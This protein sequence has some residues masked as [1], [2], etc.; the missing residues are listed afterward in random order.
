MLALRA[1]PP[2]RAP[3]PRRPTSPSR[4]SNR[5]SARRGSS[6]G[7]GFRWRPEAC[8]CSEC[9]YRG[10]VGGDGV[11]ELLLVDGTAVRRLA[12]VLLILL[13]RGEVELSA[14]GARDV[15]VV[16]CH[17]A[18]DSVR[19]VVHVLDLYA[20]RQTFDTLERV[21]LFAPADAYTKDDLFALQLDADGLADAAED[22]APLD[23]SARVLL[24]LLEEEVRVE[25]VR[26]EEA[27]RDVE[28][29]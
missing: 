11:T 2:T 1:T 29:R 26:V 20:V 5:R 15:A 7:G 9:V 8:A 22:I 14:V 17:V 28:L 3:T 18:V 21:R 10:E 24:K 16:V 27:A 6:K 13:Q 19:A 25:L 12:C 4:C 23:V